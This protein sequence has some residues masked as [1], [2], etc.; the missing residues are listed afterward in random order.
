MIP[1]IFSVA[2]LSVQF[3]VKM[4]M[5]A[6]SRK[7]VPAIPSGRSFR[8]KNLIKRTPRSFGNFPSFIPLTNFSKASSASDHRMKNI[9][10]P[11]TTPYFFANPSKDS[12]LTVRSLKMVCKMTLHKGLTIPLKRAVFFLKK[13]FLKGTKYKQNEAGVVMFRQWLWLVQT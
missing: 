7:I 13:L 5:K 2:S 12:L 3:F 4:L 10:F 6:L 11:V 9:H 1:P 8:P